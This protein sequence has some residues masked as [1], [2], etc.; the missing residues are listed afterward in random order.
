MPHAGF[1]EQLFTKQRVFETD[2]MMPLGPPISS[3]DSNV[4]RQQRN[5]VSPRHMGLVGDAHPNSWQKH[6]KHLHMPEEI[7][8]KRSSKVDMAEKC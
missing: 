3:L 1:N 8:S 5:F 7:A 2:A 6:A 4:P